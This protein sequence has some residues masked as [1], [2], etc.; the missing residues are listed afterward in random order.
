MNTQSIPLGSSTAPTICRKSLP[1]PCLRA[2]R[3]L[4]SSLEHTDRHG[5]VYR[6]QS[7]VQGSQNQ[8][9]FKVVMNIFGRTL[10]GDVDEKMAVRITAEVRLGP[11]RHVR[12]KGPLAPAPS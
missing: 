8:G 5:P 2:P 10:T 11:D 6:S 9:H 7:L 3:G 4:C 1:L 12:T